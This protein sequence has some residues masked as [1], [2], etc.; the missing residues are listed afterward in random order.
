MSHE[1]ILS[2]IKSV[3]LEVSHIRNN[4]NTGFKVYKIDKID[5]L[6]KTSNKKMINHIISNM[7]YSVLN[8]CKKLFNYVNIFKL[9]YN[10]NYKQISKKYKD[11]Y[12]KLYS[13]S[14]IY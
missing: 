9:N 7:F 10:K 5:V 11:K 12:T 6:S 1:D 8:K 3:R 13:D 4:L 2:E 14:V